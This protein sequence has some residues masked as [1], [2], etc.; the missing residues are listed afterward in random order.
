MGHGRVTVVQNAHREDGIK[1]RQSLWHVLYTQGQ[2]IHRQ[3]SAGKVFDRLKLKDKLNRGINAN[4]PLG[5]CAEHA[6]AVITIAT[7]HIQH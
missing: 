4:N 7:T 1:G 3:V 5:T 6:P 2:H